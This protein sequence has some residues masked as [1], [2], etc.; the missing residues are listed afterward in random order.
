MITNSFF[1]D[2]FSADSVVLLFSRIPVL[3]V[4]DF[5]S[6]DWLS[7]ISSIPLCRGGAG[8]GDGDLL[9]VVPYI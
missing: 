2:F 3:R 5:F 9:L 7:G 1:A 4:A 6:D 8:D